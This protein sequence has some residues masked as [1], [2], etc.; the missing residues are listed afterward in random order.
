MEN[1]FL[2][3]YMVDTGWEHI[4]DTALVVADSEEQSIKKLKGSISKLGNDYFVEHI[5]EIKRFEGSIFSEN[6]VL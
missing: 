2:I 4:R 6:F 3:K 1:L 5:F